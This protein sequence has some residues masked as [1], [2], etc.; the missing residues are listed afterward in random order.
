MKR[1]AATKMFADRRDD[2]LCFWEQLSRLLNITCLV[3]PGT[4]KAKTISTNVETGS[5]P[6]PVLGRSNNW[7]STDFLEATDVMQRVSHDL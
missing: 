6:I 1:S 3:S 7:H 5:Q 2:T 4:E